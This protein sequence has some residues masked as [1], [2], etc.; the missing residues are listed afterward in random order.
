M[1]P[2]VPVLRGTLGTLDLI[3]QYDAGLREDEEDEDDGICSGADHQLGLEE[4]DSGQY[5]SEHQRNGALRDGPLSDA[6]FRLQQSAQILHPS[7]RLLSSSRSHQTHNSLFQLP[8][9]SISTSNV[10]RQP[11][12]SAITASSSSTLSLRG[13]VASDSLGTRT[14][15]TTS[16]ST[17]DP[18]GM[19]FLDMTSPSNSDISVSMPDLIVIP[20]GQEFNNGGVI[21]ETTIADAGPLTPTAAPPTPARSPGL[22][23]SLSF[24][25]APAALAFASTP[26][27]ISGSVDFSRPHIA[28]SSAHL[29]NGGPIDATAPHRRSRAATVEMVREVIGVRVVDLEQIHRMRLELASSALLI[30]GQRTVRDGDTAVGGATVVAARAQTDGEDRSDVVGDPAVTNSDPQTPRRSRL[31][32]QNVTP[33]RPMPSSLTLSLFTTPPRPSTMYSPAAMEVLRALE[34]SPEVEQRLFTAEELNRRQRTQLRRPLSRDRFS[35]LD[36]S[37]QDD[38]TQMTP[39]LSTSAISPD[40]DRIRIH[41]PRRQSDFPASVTHAMDPTEHHPESRRHRRDERL[42][43]GDVVWWHN[44]K[45]AGDISGVSEERFGSR[46]GEVTKATPGSVQVPWAGWCL[47][48]RELDAKRVERMWRSARALR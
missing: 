6:T 41:N 42:Q 14:R 22:P 10:I 12:I 8:P 1:G 30:P 23:S 36:Q 33:N 21:G 29:V 3:A 24:P 38:H 17:S 25:E 43:H 4:D 31:T 40:R 20:G 9:A 18:P 5:D 28:T 13:L 32:E 44:L 16:S 48:R 46:H 11:T 2:S 26:S 27:R 47:K 45:R 39:P 15:A 19:S 7:A 37:T 35:S 34:T